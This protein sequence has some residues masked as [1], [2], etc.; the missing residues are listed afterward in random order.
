MCLLHDTYYLSPPPSLPLI[1]FPQAEQDTWLDFATSTTTVA[2]GEAVNEVLA[3][4]GSTG[5]PGTMYINAILSDLTE[6]AGGEAGCFN[7]T[8]AMVL[9]LLGESTTVALATAY[10]NVTGSVEWLSVCGLNTFTSVSLF[11][12][13]PS[14]GG[15]FLE[16]TLTHD[17]AMSGLRIQLAVNVD[18]DPVDNDLAVDDAFFEPQALEVSVEVTDVSSA[19]A[20]TA[21]MVDGG[22]NRVLL[23]MIQN[24]DQDV[25]GCLLDNVLHFSLTDWE[26]AIADVVVPSVKG[27]LDAEVSRL[28]SAFTDVATTAFVRVAKNH[29]AG[30][31]RGPIRETANELVAD[32]LEPVFVCANWEEPPLNDVY[33]AEA[34]A[35]AAEAAAFVAMDRLA[36][37]ANLTREP[38]I[39]YTTDP[40]F[41]GLRDLVA[42][43]SAAGWKIEA[44]L[45]SVATELTQ[46]G[47]ANGTDAGCVNITE[48]LLGIPI[49]PLAYS[50]PL[51]SIRNATKLLGDQASATLDIS[52]EVH[53]LSVCGLNT[54]NSASVQV[55][56]PLPPRART[57]YIRQVPQAPPLLQCRTKTVAA[58]LLTDTRRHFIAMSYH[59]LDAVDPLVYTMRHHIGMDELRV[60]LDLTLKVAI[61]DGSEPICP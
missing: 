21:F 20:T 27:L 57:T 34:A 38:L 10:G 44:L 13:E 35:I 52:V 58:S 30:L 45:N 28:A 40:M 42:N 49:P 48:E 5:A 56:P 59:R 23:G 29:L 33:V 12:Q 22:F 2:I 51:G 9:D 61:S 26:L 41:T 17:F 19:M 60:E 24:P 32:A 18:V 36:P 31:S 16:R 46:T 54:F 50:L 8:A 53:W 6:A 4:P 47:G 11:K 43:P 1:P 3:N 25:V 7:V 55:A 37:L 15:G 14:A 39:D